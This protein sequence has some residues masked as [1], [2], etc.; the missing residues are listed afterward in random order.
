MAEVGLGTKL[1][2]EL[3][4]T[5]T[6]VHFDTVVSTAAS[7]RWFEGSVESRAMEGDE[8]IEAITDTLEGA[9]G[10]VNNTVRPAS[11]AAVNSGFAND[12]LW[13]FNNSIEDV[14]DRAAKFAGRCVFSSW[15]GLDVCLDGDAKAE[16]ECDQ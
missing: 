5:I 2:W 1:R 10:A 11:F 9:A 7:V 13:D 12:L 8:L 15:R 16:C 14:G 4:E 6:G 3:G